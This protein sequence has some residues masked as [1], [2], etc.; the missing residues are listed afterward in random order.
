MEFLLRAAKKLEY[1]DGCLFSWWHSGVDGDLG[2]YHC[3]AFANVLKCEYQLYQWVRATSTEAKDNVINVIY[4]FLI[5]NHQHHKRI[6]F[7]H[8]LMFRKDAIQM[9]QECKITA[10][11]NKIL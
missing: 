1:M 3:I 9:M 7:S 8:W 5:H 11:T 6:I 4:L 10:Q 2:M